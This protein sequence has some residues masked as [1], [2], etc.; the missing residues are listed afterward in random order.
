M[1][2]MM[3]FLC[4]RADIM[5]TGTGQ[6]MYLPCA[7]AIMYKFSGFSLLDGKVETVSG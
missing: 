5:L 2:G 4:I 7:A 1:Q 6:M 3:L